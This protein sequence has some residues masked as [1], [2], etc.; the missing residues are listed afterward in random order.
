MITGA[1]IDLK[2]TQGDDLIAY[3]NALYLDLSG[4]YM[5]LYS[6]NSLSCILKLSEDHAC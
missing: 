6:K 1:G 4:D 3:G 2:G 5:G